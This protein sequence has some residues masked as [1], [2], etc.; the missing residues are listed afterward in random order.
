ML[1]QPCKSTHAVIYVS[2]RAASI[3]TDGV[4][5]LLLH[6]HLAK[7][8]QVLSFAVIIFK[9]IAVLQL[10]ITLGQA[11][12]GWACTLLHCV[13]KLAAA[14]GVALVILAAIDAAW[15]GDW[16]R[17]GVLSHDIE[18]WLQS[19]LKLLGAWHI[20]NAITAFSIA[21][22][23]G[24]PLFPLIPK[25]CHTTAVDISPDKFSVL[26]SPCDLP[27]KHP[28]NAGPLHWNTPAV[29]LDI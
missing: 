6:S 27:A 19:A 15:S 4:Q 23:S 7:Y 17:V 28:D 1:H 24:R 10:H 20:L 22:Q 25:V 16:S 8:A 2:H 29:S 26:D 5:K 11:D 18:G 9:L 21:K 12:L 3:S 13:H 14:G